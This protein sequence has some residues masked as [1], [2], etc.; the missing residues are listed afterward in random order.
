MVVFIFL[1]LS[2]LIRWLD[3]LLHLM[4]SSVIF[5]QNMVK[6]IWLSH[7]F[8]VE[9]GIILF[10]DPLKISRGPQGY[11]SYTLGSDSKEKPNVKGVWFR[12]SLHNLSRT[13]FLPLCI[14][15]VPLKVSYQEVFRAF[16]ISVT[17]KLMKW[18]GLKQI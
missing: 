9:K 12:R 7:G 6:E 13:T 2:Y 4:F 8:V 17:P 18:Y 3:S 1:H 5:V 10:V 16:V 11:F 14:K 15:C